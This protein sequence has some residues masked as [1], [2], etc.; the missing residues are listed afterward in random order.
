MNNNYTYE[1]IMEAL[2]REQP[3]I[4]TFNKVNGE[5]RIMTCTLRKEVIPSDFAPKGTG[6]DKIKENKKI[7]RAFDTNKQ[8][9]RSFRVE[10]VTKL[11]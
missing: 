2:H 10:L 8:E 7:I 11:E 9:W 4:V 1:Q 5:Q 3:A 6:L